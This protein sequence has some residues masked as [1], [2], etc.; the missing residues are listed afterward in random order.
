M[1]YE[2]DMKAPS[3]LK[4]VIHIEIEQKL[5][6]T[7]LSG[8][9]VKTC[10]ESFIT[11]IVLKYALSNLFDDLNSF[12]IQNNFYLEKNEDT[13]CAITSSNLAL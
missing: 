13:E 10:T 5:L 12:N 2:L 3:S 7:L 8:A 4:P 6:C 1:K 9:T 11:N